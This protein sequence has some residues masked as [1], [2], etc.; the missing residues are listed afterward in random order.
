MASVS[1]LSFI[2]LIFSKL[3]GQFGFCNVLLTLS[4][5]EDLVY[6]QVGDKVTLESPKVNLDQ[7]YLHWYFGDTNRQQIA[8]RNP[9]GGRGFV[10]KPEATAKLWANLSWSGN[11][12]VIKHI[13]QEHF[14][15]FACEVDGNIKA[16]YK[17]LKLTITKSSALLV[18]GENLRLSCT[19]ETPQNT[20]KPKIHWLNP[21]R[22]KKET[23]QLSVEVTGQDHGNW[24]CVVQNNVRE[25]EAK[26][27]VTVVDFSPDP[28]LQ[29]T[30]KSAPLT[31]PCSIRANISW[32]QIKAVDV[33]EVSWHFS[34]KSGSNLISSGPHRLFYLSLKDTPTW[35]TDQPRDVT[36]MPVLKGGHLSLTR[37]LGKDE[38]EGDYVC[39]MRVRGGIT[40]KRTVS[41]K[42]LQ[43]TSSPGA[44][45]ISGQ[46]VNLTCSLG[47]LLPPNLRIKW[48]PP[49]QSSLT[50]SISDHHS[51]HLAIPEVGEGDGGI[52]RCELWHDKRLTFA[53]ITLKIEP[54]LSMW[55]LVIICSVTVIIV[56]LLILVFIIYRRRQ[57]K[58]THLRHRLCKCKNPK[59]K[60][61][62]RT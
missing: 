16:T 9:L 22:E 14:G 15:T 62:Y 47:E 27:L 30:S 13:M 44:E 21:Q 35:E 32:D 20:R 34:P 58:T 12:L 7:H 10:D 8:W 24:T 50:L 43:I 2:C 45:V 53:E 41:V 48:V 56:L 25:T 6:A 5:A 33:Q 1:C 55:M 57:R 60:G 61:F 36:P 17:V 23:S 54:K 37:K 26:V 29:Y 52:W 51:P 40:L 31:V 3:A 39:S 59:P 46:Q 4:G 42:V 49:E 11:S 19:A 38:D 18:P 28:H